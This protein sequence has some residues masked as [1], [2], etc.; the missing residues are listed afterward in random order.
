MG[1]AKQRGS[2]EQRVAEAKAK[3]WTR[4]DRQISYAGRARLQW[5]NSRWWIHAVCVE[6]AR[7]S[8][9]FARHAVIRYSH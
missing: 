8:L 5:V 1:Q 7:D 3:V 9:E 6:S 2:R 4:C